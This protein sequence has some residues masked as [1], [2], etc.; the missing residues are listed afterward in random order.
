LADASAATFLRE[1][2]SD[3]ELA[4]LAET[5]RRAVHRLLPKVVPVAAGITMAP[6]SKASLMGEQADYSE[7]L[8]AITSWTGTATWVHWDLEVREPGRFAVSILQSATDPRENAF[9]VNFAGARLVGHVT[10]TPDRT[11]F[12]PVHL[13]EVEI[14]K[15]G[16]YRLFVEP[17]RLSTGSLMNLQ[18]VRLRKV[19][20]GG[21]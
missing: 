3:S 6:A 8:K 2:E 4:S 7:E 1:L 15:P 13:G 20:G 10:A 19:S 17:L 14:K 11:N 18:G 12:Q 16:V 9:R 21:A 5:A